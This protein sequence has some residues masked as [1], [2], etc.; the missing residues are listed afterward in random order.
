MVEFRWDNGKKG[1]DRMV[2]T[3]TGYKGAIR[4][5][6]QP[7]PEDM[8]GSGAALSLDRGVD[9]HGMPYI[10]IDIAN[11]DEAEKTTIKHL[12][13]DAMETQEFAV[14]LGHSSHSEVNLTLYVM[15]NILSDV[16]N[17]LK[18]IT[19]TYPM[20]GATLLPEKFVE[21]VEQQQQVRHGLEQSLMYAFGK[22]ADIKHG[23]KMPRN[24][25][26]RIQR[27]VQYFRHGIPEMRGKLGGADATTSSQS[28]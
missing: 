18:E 2:R 24:G 25:H 10:E 3:P 22:D 1:I 7:H 12:I 9:E 28:V 5:P 14:R 27:L 8:R 21:F 20:C 26:D 16:F 13:H 19:L 11:L 15:H 17:A 6:N 4:R 23:K